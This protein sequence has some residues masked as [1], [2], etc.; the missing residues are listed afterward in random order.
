MEIRDGNWDIE[1]GIVIRA[2]MPLGFYPKQAIGRSDASF[3]LD[4]QLIFSMVRFKSTQ[5]ENY[6][7][8]S[9]WL[10]PEEVRLLAS[11]AIAVEDFFG[12]VYAYPHPVG[13]KIKDD[14]YDLSEKSTQNE[15]KAA[16]FNRLKNESNK[17]WLTVDPPPALGGPD[18]QINKNAADMKRQQDIF[19]AIDLNNQL[20]I[21]GLGAFLQC[22][23]LS[24]HHIFH[25]N[26]CISLHIA[27]EAALQIILLRL[28]KTKQHPSTVDAAKYL[29]RMLKSGTT[30]KQC[31]EAYYQDRM[32]AVHPA[33]RLATYP[34]TLLS[35]DNFYELYE[36]LRA[37][38]DFLITGNIRQPYTG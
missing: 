3:V 32:A 14:G 21:S 28:G 20:L 9:N 11:I 15:C 33:G 2:Y 8:E 27:I 38:Y 4:K 36:A 30:H 18:Y 23:L 7:I 22:D 1:E 34:H 37:A 17:Y 19:K 29:D 5:L 10:I 12:K 24:V 25:H 6:Y 26:A 35:S 31:F 13:F 16:L